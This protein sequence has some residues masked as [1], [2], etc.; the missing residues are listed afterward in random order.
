[1]PAS[2]GSAVA[3]PETRRLGFDAGLLFPNNILG[4]FVTPQP[5]EHRLIQETGKAPKS[6]AEDLEAVLK[7][8]EG[9]HQ[10]PISG[11]SISH[12]DT[13]GAWHQLSWNGNGPTEKDVSSEP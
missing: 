9:W 1:M 11:F 6:V 3:K 4:V 8:I 13:K 5:E 7:K 12:R 2:C 10:G